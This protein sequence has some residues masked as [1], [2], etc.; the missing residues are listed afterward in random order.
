MAS[1]TDFRVLFRVDKRRYWFRVAVA[2]QRVKQLRLSA[3]ELSE[4]RPVS[5]DRQ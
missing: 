4:P 2:D 1:R 5:R 3:D